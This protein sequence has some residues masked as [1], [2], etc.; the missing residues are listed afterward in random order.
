ML[1]RKI[2]LKPYI[3][4]PTLNVDKLRIKHTNIEIDLKSESLYL[5]VE[6][7]YSKII[8]KDY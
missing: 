7:Y 8:L 4:I 1:K 3:R 5:N 6:K 2:H